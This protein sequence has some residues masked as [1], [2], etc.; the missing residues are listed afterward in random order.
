[1]LAVIATLFF[2]V[3]AL[4]VVLLWLIDRV[5]MDPEKIG[6]F[7][8]LLPAVGINGAAALQATAGSAVLAYDFLVLTQFLGIAAVLAGHAVLHDR[9]C[10]TLTFLLLSP[11]RRR[12]LLL[13]KVIGAMGPSFALYVAISG[14]ACVAIKTLAIVEPFGAYLPPSPA[15][16]IAFFLGGPLWAAFVSA[17]CCIVSSVARDVRTAQQLVWF[18]VFFATLFAGFLL[19][20]VLQKG[21]VVQLAVAGLGAAGLVGAL[22]VGTQIISRDVSR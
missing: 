6:N 10:G 22:I 15:W 5:A 11:V 21:A 8:S 7:E 4:V 9:Q 12:E 17:I 13:G 19:S 14:S 2:L 3:G 16:F 20:Y 18:V 1:M